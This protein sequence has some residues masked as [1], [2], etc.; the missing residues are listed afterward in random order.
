M[1]LA[2]IPEHELSTR[3]QAYL[4][5]DITPIWVFAEGRMTDG[6][7]RVL[8]ALYLDRLI[9]NVVFAREVGS[10]A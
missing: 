1:Q 6:C 8:D 7:S 2:A 10:A 3:S 5:A 9:A 4:A